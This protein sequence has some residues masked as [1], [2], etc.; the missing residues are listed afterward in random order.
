MPVRSL[1]SSVLKWPNRKTVDKAVR[2]WAA[3]FVKNRPEVIRLG[4]FG[5]YLEATGAWAAIWI[6]WL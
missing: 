4:Y 5:S 2:H 3:R 1:N 6:W